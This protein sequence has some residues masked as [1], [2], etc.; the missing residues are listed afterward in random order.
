MKHNNSPEHQ[1]F[2]KS[3]KRKKLLVSATQA[4]ILISFF[5]LWEIAARLGWVEAFIFSSP[6]RMWAMLLNMIES[7]EIFR[8][9]AATTWSVVV[10]FT[11]G[12]L[13]GT[14]IAVVLW[15]NDFTRRVLNPYLVVFNALPKTALAP[16]II[17]WIGNNSRAVIV[18]ALLISVVVTVLNMLTGFIGVEEDKI[19]LAQSFGAKKPTILRKIVFPSAVPDLINALKINIGLS[20]VGVIVG[21]FLVAQAGLG[22]LIVYG[23]QIFIFRYIQILF[24]PTLALNR[25]GN[26]IHKIGKKIQIY[27]DPIRIDKDFICVLN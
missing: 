13:L 5:A 4:L 17:V 25:I 20:F 23:S 21:E 16:I 2:L 19:K 8:H 3:I 7:G 10:G 18:T 11:L 24:T 14:A 22:F 27:F 26:F 15:A 9:M 6:T 12:T 1:S